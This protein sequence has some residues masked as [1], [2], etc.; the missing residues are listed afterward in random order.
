[1]ATLEGKLLIAVPKL[2][3]QNFF[4]SVVLLVRHNNGGAFGLTLNRAG[5]M[6]VPEVWPQ[7]SKTACHW[8]QPLRI[9]GP[10]DGP[11]MV[12]HNDSAVGD[13]PIV[14]GVFFGVDPDHLAKL[15]ANATAQAQFY[16]GYCGWGAGQLEG[17]LES[18]AWLTATATA[19]HVFSADDELW[20]KVTREVGGASLRK[21]LNL[22]HLPP[23][24][25]CN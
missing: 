18:G 22:K 1:M 23:D 6:Q 24:P 9:G 17:E 11:L 12:L 14:P 21:V 10:V 3:D 13:A 5:G 7:F 19:T 4:H 16:V 8:P 25:T 15:F 2:H 20:I